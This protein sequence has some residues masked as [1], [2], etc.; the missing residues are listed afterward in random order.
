[1]KRTLQIIGIII[2]IALLLANMQY[3]F[4]GYGI[5]GGTLAQEVLDQTNLPGY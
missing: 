1:M 5:L 4:S 2:L 3:A